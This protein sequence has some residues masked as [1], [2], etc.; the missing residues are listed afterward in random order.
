MISEIS[1]GFTPLSSARWK[2][3]GSSAVWPRAIRTE[4]V[5]TLRSRGDNSERFQTSP[6]SLACV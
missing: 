4:T 2:L 3:N 6:K 1:A 5:T